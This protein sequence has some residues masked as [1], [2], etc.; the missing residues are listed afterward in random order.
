MGEGSEENLRIKIDLA[1]RKSV[2]SKSKD[3][4]TV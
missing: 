4:Q 3:G 1:G 2:I